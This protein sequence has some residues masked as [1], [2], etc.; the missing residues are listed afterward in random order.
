[1]KIQAEVSLYP[2]RTPTLAPTLDLFLQ[3]LGEKHISLTPGTMSSRVS[4]EAADVFN[5][6]SQAFTEAARQ[7]DVVLIVK[8]SNAC[9]ENNSAD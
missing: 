4:G 6:L 1:M 7:R 5:A 9:P 8:A 3:R 2:L